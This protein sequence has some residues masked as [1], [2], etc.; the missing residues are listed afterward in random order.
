VRNELLLITYDINEYRRYLC[1]RN[2][3]LASGL[4]HAATFPTGTSAVVASAAA[5]F[6]GICLYKEPATSPL[7]EAQSSAETPKSASSP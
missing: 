7:I 2:L 5:A 1:R 3:A 4:M 6:C